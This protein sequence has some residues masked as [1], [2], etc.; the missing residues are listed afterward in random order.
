MTYKNGA[1]FGPLCIVKTMEN[2]KIFRAVE[3]LIF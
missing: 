1:I 3:M 2:D